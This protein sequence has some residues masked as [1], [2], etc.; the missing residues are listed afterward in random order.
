[1]FPPVNP[2]SIK[3][4]G[5]RTR[6]RVKAGIFRSLKRGAHVDKKLLT[7]NDVSELLSISARQVWNLLSTGRLPWPIRLGRSVRWRRDEV[8]EWM[9]AGCPPHERW[10]AARRSTS[11]KALATVKAIGGKSNEE[12]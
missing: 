1:M 2:L 12:V 11:K 6:L 7:V 4:K 10:N 5:L 3:S 8:T 9:E